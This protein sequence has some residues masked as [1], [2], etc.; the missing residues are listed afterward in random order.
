MK[1]D[2]FFP[3]AI[4]KSKIL[5]GTQ[6]L[7]AD[8]EFAAVKIA[9]IIQGKDVSVHIRKAHKGNRGTA[10]LILQIGTRWT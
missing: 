2:Y 5:S 4:F 10:L 6:K 1:L 3:H 7:G 8:S 9:C